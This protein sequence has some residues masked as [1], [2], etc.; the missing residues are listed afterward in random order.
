MMAHNWSNI[1]SPLREMSPEEKQILQSVLD[2]MRSRFVQ[3]AR[4]RRPHANTETFAAVT[5]G[6]VVTAGQAL[7]AGL[8]DRIGYLDDTLAIARQR[9]G[10]T[11]AR[12]VLYRRGSEYAENIYSS[13]A[14]GPRR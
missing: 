12:V 14:P 6:R 4:E 10:L 5:D 7:Q 8:I 2:D 9:A 13:I 3:L 1:G 11:T